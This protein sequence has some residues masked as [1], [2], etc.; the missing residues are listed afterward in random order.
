[1]VVVSYK[2][3]T[4]E[5]GFDAITADRKFHD[6]CLASIR[7]WNPMMIDIEEQHRQ[8]SCLEY[9]LDALNYVDSHNTIDVGL[10]ENLSRPDIDLTQTLCHDP[11]DDGTPATCIPKIVNGFVAASNAKSGIEKGV[12]NDKMSIAMQEIIARYPD[13]FQGQ[14]CNVYTSRVYSDSRD[15]TT[16]FEK[17]LEDS[18][19]KRFIDINRTPDGFFDAPMCRVNDTVGSMTKCYSAIVNLALSSASP[20]GKPYVT[21]NATELL[22]N[23][24]ASK[25]FEK[26]L[27]TISGGCFEGNLSMEY[28]CVEK[29]LNSISST[30]RG[31]YIVKS[32][33][34]TYTG[35]DGIID[36][37]S[38][39]SPFSGK[40]CHISAS[41][42]N[43]Q[44]CLDNAVKFLSDKINSSNTNAGIAATLMIEYIASQPMF[45]DGC[46]TLKF[47]SLITP[48]EEMLKSGLN[49]KQKDYSKS[50][51]NKIMKRFTLEPLKHLTCTSEVYPEPGG[52]R[53]RTHRVNGVD[54]ALE[55]GIPIL[56]QMYY[57]GES[58]SMLLTELEKTPCVSIHTGEPIPC[59]QKLTNELFIDYTDQDP[60]LN[61]GSVSII[62]SILEDEQLDVFNLIYPKGKPYFTDY[63]SDA[64]YNAISVNNKTSSEAIA[65]L[66][67]M[68]GKMGDHVKFGVDPFTSYGYPR[69]GKIID[70][71]NKAE[72]TY[73]EKDYNHK[74]VF[75]KPSKVKHSLDNG[76]IHTED[77]V[78]KALES[79]LFK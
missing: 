49:T 17:L 68:I 44:N 4:G 9:I 8:I 16:C 46:G 39:T 45:A 63:L 72:V 53:G 14:T 54:Y 76:F 15:Y 70:I 23:M 2:F 10:F 31:V 34:D 38:E 11:L 62:K 18:A 22:I 47:L 69:F 64:I 6:T 78:V 24:I 73:P 32:L 77:D 56:H 7:D 37:K 13:L 3:Y 5:R 74:Q 43:H 51:S 67:Y 55:L 25:K 79:G 71:I 36:I 75:S 27:Y 52:D 12:W 41:S 26:E 48:L 30:P 61:R 19:I 59:I 57:N 21:S 20:S 1:M 65:L 42:A 33:I 35:D 29:I 60:E 50:I 40:K 58:V 28:S 66:E